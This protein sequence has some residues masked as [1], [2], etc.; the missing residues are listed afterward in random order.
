MGLKSLKKRTKNGE[1]AIVATD[2]SGRLA[3]MSKSEYERKVAEHTGSDPIV[4]Q[5]DV[6][7]MEQISVSNSL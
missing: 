4:S 5:S 3:V 6:T 1:A 2:K 7:E